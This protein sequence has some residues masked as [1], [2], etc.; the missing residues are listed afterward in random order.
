MQGF[1]WATIW[2][3]T[4]LILCITI[5]YSVIQP[6][7]TA[8]AWL[9]CLILFAAYKYT[10]YWCADQPDYLETGGRFYVKALKTIFVSLYLEEICLAGLFFLSTDQNGGRTPSGLACGAIMVSSAPSL[11]LH[12]RF[13]VD[14]CRLSRLSSRPLSKS[15]ST[16]SASNRTTSFTLT[17]LTPSRTASWVRLPTRR[18]SP[19]P[20]LPP[21]LPRARSA[22]SQPR[23][24]R[25]MPTPALSTAT[26]LVSTTRL[27]TT[28]PCGRIS[29]SSGLLTILSVSESSKSSASN[30]SM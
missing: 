30:H 13:V 17:R 6:I 27:S 9:A 4:C 3:P 10:L 20:R 5:V 23:L 7:I 25:R 16:G 2:P 1:A 19:L 15:T 26:R 12:A 8:L 22:T 28:R 11:L 24:L 18:A 29:P 21:R 14:C